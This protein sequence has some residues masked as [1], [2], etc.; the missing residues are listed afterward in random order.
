MLTPDCRFM[1][2][3]GVMAH[4]II[5]FRIIA[6]TLYGIIITR[7]KQLIPVWVPLHK[8]H[9]LGVTAC[10]SCAFEFPIFVHLPDPDGFVPAAGGEVPAIMVPRN[11]LHFIFVPLQFRYLL[12]TYNFAFI[13]LT[14]NIAIVLLSCYWFLIIILL[15]WFRINLPNSSSSIETRTRKD[16]SI[17]MPANVS[18]RTLMCIIYCCLYYHNY[19]LISSNIEPNRF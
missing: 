6:P 1:S 12:K 8:L 18:Y 14:T 13:F 9:I 5:H 19:L 10:Y 16:L 15:L 11:T 17:R 3:H 2:I 7:R 4:P